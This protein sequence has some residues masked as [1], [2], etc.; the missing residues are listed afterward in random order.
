ML[1]GR[2]F[3]AIGVCEELAMNASKLAPRIAIEMN[4][5]PCA[6][7]ES[8]DGPC[9]SVDLTANCCGGYD[10]LESLEPH[11]CSLS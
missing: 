10:K 5:D 3:L 1:A 2:L 11:I 9:C 7:S 6:A 4:H 8:L